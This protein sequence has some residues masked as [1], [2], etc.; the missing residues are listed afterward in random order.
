[1]T[2]FFRQ[3]S[4]VDPATP[5]LGP[6]D[7]AFYDAGKRALVAPALMAWLHRHARR[8]A[9]DSLQPGARKA[10]MHAANPRFVLRNY[11]A[12]EAIDRAEQGDLSVVS[13]LLDV[14]RLPY[15]DQQ[16]RESFARRR[17]DWARDRAGCSM[18]SCSS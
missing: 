18:L 14:M 2:I 11:L 3:L 15:D 1:M 10:R 4:Q 12:H 17:P 5:G 16:G 13:E 6:L 7:E 8:V 9:S